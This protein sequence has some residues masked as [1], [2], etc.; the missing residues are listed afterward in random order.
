MRTLYES[1]FD[2]KIH[3][4][5][6]DKTVKSQERFDNVFK[7][8]KIS[9]SDEEVLDIFD[10]KKIENYFKDSNFNIRNIPI[11]IVSEA[12]IDKRLNSIIQLIGN[13]NLIDILKNPHTY[14][15][16][17]LGDILYK[18]ISHYIKT[19]NL[20]LFDIEVKRYDDKSFLIIISYNG[21]DISLLIEKNNKK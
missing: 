7:I 10:Y 4:R 5:N 9:Y 16:L 15:Y 12:K 18:L 3:L 14:I 8:V 6:I 2:T 17:K 11:E 19:G 13:A 1:I 21:H 20:K